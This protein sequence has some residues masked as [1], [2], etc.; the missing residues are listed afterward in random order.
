MPQVQLCTRHRVSRDGCGRDKCGKQ[1]LH[2]SDPHF[3][4][5]RDDVSKTRHMQE[6][7][8]SIYAYV[9]PL[10]TPCITRARVARVGA[11][12][13]LAAGLGICASN[14]DQRPHR[15]IFV[16][17][18]S[19]L[20]NGVGQCWPHLAQHGAAFRHLTGAPVQWAPLHM[21]GHICAFTISNVSG[22]T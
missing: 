17:Q 12:L 8:S 9:P 3:K 13:L 20:Q 2:W 6:L 19:F 21:E 16:A 10:W 15:S 4:S 22:V 18:W 14:L 1:P 11:R 7:I 5:K